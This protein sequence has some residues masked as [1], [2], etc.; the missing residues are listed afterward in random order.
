MADSSDY[1]VLLVDDGS[2]QALGASLC[3]PYGDRCQLVR[4]PQN[5][6]YTRTVNA[7]LGMVDSDTIVLM[8]SDC[9]A[10]TGWYQNLHTALNSAE[11]IGAAG[12]LSNAASWQSVPHRFDLMGGW[13][14]NALPKGYTVQRFAEL[15]E[16]LS[17]RHYPSVPLLNGFCVAYRRSAISATGLFDEEHFP[18]G[19]GEEND[20]FIR[21]GQ[22]GYRCI[23]ADDT[24][25]YH[26]KSQS[27]GPEAA[28]LSKQGGRNFNKKWGQALIRQHLKTL[29]SHPQLS[30][31]RRN[32]RQAL[33]NS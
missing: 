30:W 4:Q 8:N 7:A 3:E 32:I 9:V 11:D 17:Q 20:Y 31:T 1:R 13:K 16:N 21:M 6:G 5:L 27:F 2:P 24:W 14:V 15:V 25:V 23:V 18:R 33:L 19:Y 26:A 12:P 29:S 22:A 28:Q 10:P